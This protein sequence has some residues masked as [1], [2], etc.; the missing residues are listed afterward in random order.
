M[1]RRKFILKTATAS[2]ALSS[3]SL[4]NLN[5][6]SYKKIL[7]ANDRVRVGLIGAGGRGTFVS[8][9]MIENN[10]VEFGA[11]C[12]LYP[13]HLD[14]A[15]E[16]AGKKAKTYKDFR[17]LLDQKDLDAVLMATPDHWHAIPAVMAAQ[18]GKDLYLEK[19]L[20]HNVRE[21]QAIQ[22]AVKENN[23]VFQTGTQ[24]RSAPHW[25]VV[26]QIIQSGE[27]GKVR[28]VRVW[29]CQ[30]QFPEGIGSVPDS[31]PPEGVDWD[32]Y[33][34]PAP[35]VPYNKMRFVGTYRWF[36]DY[37]GG[38]IT[39]YAAH[40]FDSMHQVMGEDAP[41]SVSAVGKLYDISDGGDIPDVLQVTYEYPSF[42]MSYEAIRLNA[43]GSGGRTA[44]MKYYNAKG[45][46]DRPNGL[47]FYGTNGTLFADRIGF[48]IYPEGDRMERKSMQVGDSTP[49]HTVNFIDCVKGRKQTVAPVEVGHKGS[50]ACHLG[51]IAARTGLKF[52]WDAE[53]EEITNAPEAAKLLGRE[54]RKPWDMI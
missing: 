53:K 25:E 10:N 26:R 1:Q 48:E 37:C 35:Y 54:A 19:P 49:A 4:I 7:G 24:H 12:D 50:N 39:D 46:T 27:L 45:E 29:N 5:A 21:G 17:N 2:A 22:K 52:N 16:W 9:A 36:S 32:F 41:K 3:F 30:N 33:L 15:R 23:I 38:I 34:G 13:V 44:G 28:Y 31:N 8:K 40:R 43:H 42:V 47:A 11:I 6:A 18:A 51:N 20:G 14:R